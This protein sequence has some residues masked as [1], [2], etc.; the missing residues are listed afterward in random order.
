MHLLC[1]YVQQTIESEPILAPSTV[2]YAYLFDCSGEMDQ[3]YY[4]SF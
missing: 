3:I 1:I 2:K 4:R